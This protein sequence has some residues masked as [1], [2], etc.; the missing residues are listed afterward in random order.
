V[1]VKQ[2]KTIKM[3]RNEEKVPGFDDIIFENRNKE[4]GAYD[5]RKR[6]NSVK[7]LSIFGAIAFCI[8]PLTVVFL[9]AEKGTATTGPVTFV[10]IE[11][12]VYTP[13][14]IKQPE[15]KMP[16]ELIKIPQNIAPE[17]TTDTTVI[18][19][20]LPITDVINQTLTDGDVN[21]TLS[22]AVIPE[23]IGPAE[24]EIFIAVEEMPEFPGGSAALLEFISKNTVYPEDAL[25][26]NIQGRVMLK[27]VVN[28]DGS[29]GRI[30]VLRSIDPLLDMEAVRVVGMLPR[31]RPGRQNGVPVPVWHSVP[32]SFKIEDL[33]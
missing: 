26:N 14:I 24:P 18:T 33:R 12:D 3:K 19:S 29:V 6:Y 20:Y 32:V 22:V 1:D 23:G 28:A 17:V 10:I 4:Y 25:R 13:E 8:I 9:T 21:D 16:P 27:F 5:L 31:F 11:P 15:I 30:D 2:L 7:S